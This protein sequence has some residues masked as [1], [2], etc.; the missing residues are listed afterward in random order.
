MCATYREF[1]YPSSDNLTLFCREYAPSTYPLTVLC[2]PGLTRNSKDFAALAARLGEHYRV[3]TPDLRGRG[4]SQ[5]DP[6]WTNYHPGTYL[7]DVIRLLDHLGIERVVVIGTSLGGMLA[8]FLAATQPQR[9]AVVV[10]NDVGPEISA[11]GLARIRDYVGRSPP[12]ADWDA[13]IAQAQMNYAVAPPGLTKAQWRACTEASY[14]TTRDGQVVA[15]YDPNIGEA[16]R[17]G[18]GTP[19]DL[20]PAFRALAGVPTLSLRG[21]TSDVLKQSTFDRMAAEKPDLLRVIVPNRGHPPLLDEPESV[22]AI[23]EFIERL[24]RPK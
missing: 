2:L 5:R 6:Q 11:D 23:D 1:T 14:R 4:D 8:M 19:L 3:L 16:L 9:I 24:A 18:P 15:D 10:L 13:A 22:Q 12:A 21:A 7:Q 17:N 20:W